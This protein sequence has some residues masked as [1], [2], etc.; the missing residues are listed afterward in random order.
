M[1]LG[2]VFQDYVESVFEYIGWFSGEFVDVG[3]WENELSKEKI[4]SDPGK[5]SFNESMSNI[6]S[7]N[8]EDSPESHRKNDAF[9]QGTFG[10]I[11][12]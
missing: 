8:N 4:E 11:N 2:V 10:K 1:G 5:I 9:N 12:S 3:V 7:L 6:S